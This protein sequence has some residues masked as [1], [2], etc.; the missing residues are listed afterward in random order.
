MGH[1]EWRNTPGSANYGLGYPPLWYTETNGVL[2]I[3]QES[4]GGPGDVLHEV[5]LSYSAAATQ[6]GGTLVTDEHQLWAFTTFLIGEVYE[7][8]AGGFPDPSQPTEQGHAIRAMADVD[9]LG[10]DYTDYSRG[11]VHLS[12]DGVVRSQARRGPNEYGPG[13]PEM[14]VGVW[15]SNVFDTSFPGGM[16]SSY[17]VMLSCLWYVP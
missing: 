9:A 3:S 13:H 10:I 16:L 7:V 11:A 2:L 8:G 1:Y 15:T 6:T 14:R 12:T 17:A 5:Q 4:P